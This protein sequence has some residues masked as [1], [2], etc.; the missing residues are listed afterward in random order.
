MEH[1]LDDAIGEL[2][3]EHAG[4]GLAL[5]AYLGNLRTLA[6]AHAD[7]DV[8]TPT[9]WLALLRAAFQPAPEV[10]AMMVVGTDAYRAWDNCVA[11]QIRDLAEMRAAGALDDEHR[12]FGINA[13]RG[14]R[15]FNFDP[16]TYLE[17]AAAGTFEDADEPPALT[18]PTLTAFLEAGRLYE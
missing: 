16:S 7:R 13:P 12:Y 4:L 2:V 5:E 14:A 11:E 3:R 15:W 17:C 18:W 9:E 8:L 10:A 1:T 6:R